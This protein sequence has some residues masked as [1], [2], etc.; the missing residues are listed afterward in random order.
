MNDMGRCD[1]G[2]RRTT[3]SVGTSL[4]RRPSTC[5]RLSRKP[6][7]P[8]THCRLAGLLH[9]EQASVRFDV[10]VECSAGARFRSLIPVEEEHHAIIDSYCGTVSGTCFHRLREERNHGRP[11]SDAESG[12]AR[13]CRR[14]RSQRRTWRARRSWRSWRPR[15]T[16]RQRHTWQARR[17]HGHHHSA[18]GQEIELRNRPPCK[19]RQGASWQSMPRRALRHSGLM[20][21]TFM[22]LPMRSKSANTNC[23]KSSGLGLPCGARPCIA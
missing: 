22:S 11:G 20:P 21:A 8:R 23:A 18:G 16:R 12:A 17:R 15:P 10:R 19:R 5:H 9:L 3:G 4:P 13:S 6:G 14:P 1:F 2:S 7:W